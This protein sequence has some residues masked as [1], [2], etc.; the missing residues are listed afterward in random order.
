MIEAWTGI[1]TGNSFKLRRTNSCAW[2]PSWVSAAHRADA[3]R[4]VSTT[5]LFGSRAG[6]SDRIV[7]LDLR[8]T[9]PG[10]RVWVDRAG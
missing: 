10:T 3:V 4:A 6:L 5:A 2:K 8:F 9:V 1:P 7:R